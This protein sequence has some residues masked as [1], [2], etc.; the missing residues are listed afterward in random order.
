[1]K[2]FVYFLREM[3]FRI[4]VKTQTDEEKLITFKEISKKIYYKC[5]FIFS[6]INDLESLDNYD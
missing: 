6:S 4:I 3:E 5:D 1:M 2:N